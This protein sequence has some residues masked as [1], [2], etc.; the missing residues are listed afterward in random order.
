MCVPVALLALFQTGAISIAALGGVC[1]GSN[2]AGVEVMK[3]KVLVVPPQRNAGSVRLADVLHL[4]DVFALL[5]AKRLLPMGWQWACGERG[6]AD[7]VG[8][9]RRRFEGGWR[10]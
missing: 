4:G 10:Y 5:Q 7:A 2:D 6:V 3:M 1:G 9:G 8:D